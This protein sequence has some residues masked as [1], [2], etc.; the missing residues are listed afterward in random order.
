MDKRKLIGTIIGVLMFAAL[1]V[2]A[3]YAWLTFNANVIN[4]TAN[5]TTLKYT[6]NYGKGTDIS[7]VPILVNGTKSTTSKVT[8]TAQR[9]QGSIADNIKIYLTTTTSNLTSSSGVVKYVVCVDDEPNWQCDDNFSGRV[10][11]SVQK[12]ADGTGTTVEIYSG[13]LPG[14][15]N[16]DDNATMTYNIYF[17]LDAATLTN[18]HLS[19][20][21][22]TYSGYIHAESTQSQTNYG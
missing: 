14:D 18:D 16:K 11:Q 12:Q 9:P 13:S 20:T 21:N 19:E 1:I 3:T 22:K 4:S 5:G 10:I 8:L 7:D 15:T 6:V 17:W 2:G